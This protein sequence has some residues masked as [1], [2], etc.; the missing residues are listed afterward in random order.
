MSMPATEIPAAAPGLRRNYLSGF[1]LTFQSV[2][3]VAPSASMAL[4][5]PVIFAASGA[6][7]CLTVALAGFGVLLLALQMAVFGR[8]MASPGA[9]YAY[10]HAGL[11]P[12]PGVIAGGSILVAYV[13]FI[14]TIPP[15]VANLAIGFATARLG[16][17]PGLA[18]RLGFMAA[19]ILLPWALA[20]RDIRLSTRLTSVVEIATMGLL[21]AVAALHFRATGVLLDTRQI[22]LRGFTFAQFHHGVILA[23]LLYGGFETAMELGAEARSPF[24]VIPRI[25]VIVIAILSGFNI[26]VSYATVDA[27][28]GGHLESESSPMVALAHSLGHDGIGLMITLG[29]FSSLLA[30]SVGC[31]NAAARVLYAFAHRGLFFRSI[32]RPH[33]T[34]ATP[35][36]GI[37]V[38]S[39]AGLTIALILT[40][41]GVP[42]L[43]Q[44]DYM[45]TMSSLAILVPY[46]F[47]AAAAPVYLWKRKTMKTR[48]VI[49]AVLAIGFVALPLAGSVYPVPDYPVDL[50]P[51]LYLG[52]VAAGV[53]GYLYVRKAHPGRIRGMEGELLE[54]P[55]QDRGA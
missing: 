6:G 55:P 27:F 41:V 15:Q 44:L 26:L 40:L 42:P 14:A 3:T 28:E 5:T 30:C 2:G 38:V 29:L 34:H 17:H 10:V 25:L 9:L 51:Y 50:I 21:I 23:F 8:R 20:R 13:L 18:V 37:A 52:L 36:R 7:T 35:H 49:G 53:A 39:C 32:A 19:S 22:D 24:T 45:G 46:A 33:P 4:L 16:L 12:L 43:R 11:G 31:I 54:Q 48:H 1:E 47:V